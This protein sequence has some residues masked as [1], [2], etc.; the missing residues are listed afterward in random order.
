MIFSIRAR[1]Y[2]SPVGDAIETREGIV[3]LLGTIFYNFN[4]FVGEVNF[5]YEKI[6]E[7]NR[8]PP[9]PGGTGGGRR[10]KRTA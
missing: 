6:D 3:L 9:A 4:P 1:L 5:F 2:H 7:K 8:Y 10:R